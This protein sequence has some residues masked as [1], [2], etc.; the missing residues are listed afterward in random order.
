LSDLEPLSGTMTLSADGKTF[1]VDPSTIA[2][3]IGGC[4]FDRYVGSFVGV[5]GGSAGTASSPALPSAAT[6][7]EREAVARLALRAIATVKKIGLTPT[8]A[9]ALRGW[10]Q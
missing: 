6:L 5:F 1:T 3:T 7:I 9:P 10:K 8:P 4:G 2:F